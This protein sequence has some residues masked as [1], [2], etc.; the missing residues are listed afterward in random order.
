MMTIT[1]FAADA[2]SGMRG[3]GEVSLGSSEEVVTE[4]LYL[5]RIELPRNRRQ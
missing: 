3:Q 4:W 5:V 2:D 1:P